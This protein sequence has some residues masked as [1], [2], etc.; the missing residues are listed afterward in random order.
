MSAGEPG[1][2]IVARATWDG[3]D[4]SAKG[5]ALSPIRVKGKTAVVDAWEL[6]AA[7]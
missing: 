4:G 3:L 1:Q 5:R 7:S 6:N 2:V